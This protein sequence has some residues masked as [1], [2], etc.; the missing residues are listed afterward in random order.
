MPHSTSKERDIESGNDYFGA[1][2]YASSM[3]RFMS[4]D[5]SAKIMPVPYAK[6]DNPQSLNLYAYVGNN[7]L[8][9]FDPDGHWMCNG[10]KDSCAK[11]SFALSGARAALKNLDP[12]STE[13]K[14]LQAVTGLYGK[15]N[16]ENGVNVSFGKMEKGIVGDTHVG[17]DGKTIN[18][19]FDLN[20]LESISSHADRLDAFAL[21]AGVVVHEGTHGVDERKLGRDP[22]T[23]AE[24]NRTEHNAYRNESFFFQGFGTNDPESPS[25]WH[26]G[27]TEDERSNAIDSHSAGSVADWCKGNPAC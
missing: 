18:I 21:R 9:R 13:A 12:G 7:P 11:I 16:T 26:Y 27:I 25:L 15:D 20:Q 6:L 3:G 19:K 22:S 10:S 8:T 17:A 2:Y 5:W 1:R 14:K 24:E 23:K 4:P